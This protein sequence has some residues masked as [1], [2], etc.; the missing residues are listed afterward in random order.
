MSNHADKFSDFSA[1]GQRMWELVEQY[2]D[3]TG[4]QRG[5]KAPGLDASPPVIDCSG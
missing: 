2:T 3:R 1:A 5:P 4:Y